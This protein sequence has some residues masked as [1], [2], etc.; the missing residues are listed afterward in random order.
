MCSFYNPS[1]D[2]EEHGEFRLTTSTFRLDGQ[3]VQ[4]HF[5]K[6]MFSPS[7][8]PYFSKDEAIAAGKAMTAPQR[9]L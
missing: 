4:E 7:V 9:V 1:V 5:V 8:G 3:L 2:V 6:L